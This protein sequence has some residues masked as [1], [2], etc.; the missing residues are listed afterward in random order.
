[1]GMLREEEWEKM[2]CAAAK[3]FGFFLTLGSHTASVNSKP[4][5]ILLVN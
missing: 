3:G 1:M 5:H 4:R 2:L